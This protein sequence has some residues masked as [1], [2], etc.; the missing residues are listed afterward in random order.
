M[1]GE[2]GIRRFGCGLVQEKSGDFPNMYAP[3]GGA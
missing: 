3:P 2:T 1:K